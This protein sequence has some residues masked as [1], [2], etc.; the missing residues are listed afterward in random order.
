MKLGRMLNTVGALMLTSGCAT[1]H[2][3][4][5]KILPDCVSSAA[6]A[7][8]S[9]AMSEGLLPYRICA[10]TVPITGEHGAKLADLFYTAYLASGSPVGDRPITF[11]WNGGPGS[12]SRLLQ[13]HSLGPKVQAGTGLIG[14]KVTPLRVSD[15]VFL[16]P[17][18][19]SF[20]RAVDP[21][22]AKQLYSTLGDIEATAQFIRTFRSRYG[23]ENSPL[24][25]VGESFGTWRAAGTAELLV[26]S[27]VPVDGIVLVSGGIPLGDESD[28]AMMRALSLPNRTATAI[29]LGEIS[30]IL[31]DEVEEWSKRVWYPALRDPNALSDDERAEVVAGLS[32]FTGIPASM[33]D[34]ESLWM[35]PRQFRR[36]LM[37]DEGKILGIFDMRVTSTESFGTGSEAAI[38]HFYRE[39]LGYTD[40]EYAGLETEPLPVGSQWQYD[41]A[42]ITEESLARAMA[43]EGPPSPSQPWT[44]RTLE[45]APKMRVM[46]ATGLYDSLNA[47]LANEETIAALGAELAERFVHKCYQGGHMMYADPAVAR[48]FGNDVA[49]FL[50][51]PPP[52][53]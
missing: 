38:M 11:V 51:N 35:S 23:R 21:S 47:C 40:G 42:P 12:D 9:I 52:R 39:T 44:R 10:G 19:T 24:Y 20:S 16:D 26:K 43:G 53:E 50:S 29:A 27:G 32:R 37:A 7:V 13:F 45:K 41:Q 5:Q 46:V 3:N 48:K 31:A 22:A 28:R 18:G 25:L 33:I 4:D 14:N 49:S 15:L 1:H 36:G 30:P 34:A 2:A 8:D 17:A 6:S